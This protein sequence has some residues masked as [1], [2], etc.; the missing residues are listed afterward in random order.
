MEPFQTITPQQAKRIMDSDPDCVILDVRE[1]EEY[2]TGHV[3]NAIPFTLSQID[4]EF[5]AE[6]IPSKDTRL[7]VYCKTGK[8]SRMA[9]QKL[10]SLGYR[11]LANF[12]GVESWPYELTW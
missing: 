11:N 7:L 3:E 2:V 9:C 6:C 5:A 10:W 4:A 12:G 8:R 1:V